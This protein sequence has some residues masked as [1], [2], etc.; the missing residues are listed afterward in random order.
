MLKLPGWKDRITGFLKRNKLDINDIDLI[1]SGYSG[2][3]KL[4]DI[5]TYVEDEVFTEKPAAYFKHLSGEY[6][7]AVSF[8]TWLG[9]KIIRD[10]IVPEIVQKRKYSGTAPKNILIY[11]HSRNIYHS[12][13]L[14]QQA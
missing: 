8:G 14:L 10:G 13:I 7:T 3:K 12:L 2:N 9:A 11:N 6:D 1:I 4:D 5:Y